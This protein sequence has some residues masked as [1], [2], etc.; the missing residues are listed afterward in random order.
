MGRRG[1]RRRRG[2][3]GAVCPS[4]R[5]GVRLVA[6]FLFSHFPSSEIVDANIEVASFDDVA[7]VEVLVPFGRGLQ[8]GGL[9]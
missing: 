6:A 3:S 1:C 5:R 9:S 2:C 8:W 4:C 7:S